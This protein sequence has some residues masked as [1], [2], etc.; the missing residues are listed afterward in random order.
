[1]LPP[2]PQFAT[3]SMIRV[4]VGRAARARSREAG[5]RGYIVAEGL[6]YCRGAC[7]RDLKSLKLNA[8]KIF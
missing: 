1:M 4:L 8:A 5:W 3:T 2:A 7:M 6:G